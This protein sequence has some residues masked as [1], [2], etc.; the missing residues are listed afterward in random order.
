MFAQSSLIP[1]V[2]GLAKQVRWHQEFVRFH[3]DL[4]AGF[5]LAFERNLYSESECDDTDSDCRRP[6]V[7]P[8]ITLEH[9]GETIVDMND[10]IKL[11]VTLTV[12]H[13]ETGRRDIVDDIVEWH[14][15]FQSLVAKHIPAHIVSEQ[16]HLF[17]F[18]A[19]I[20]D[21]LNV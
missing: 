19:R 8:S 21:F 16:P 15:E 4:G 5:S 1:K 6:S 9:P 18:K 11:G 20:V 17:T 10:S 12:W 14:Q 2:R 3:A 13:T 7:F